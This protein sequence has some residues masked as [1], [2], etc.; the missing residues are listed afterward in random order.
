MKKPFRDTKV[1]K[2]LSSKGVDNV[3]NVASHVIP[4]V[5]AI[6]TIKDAILGSPLSPEDKMQALD[7][8]IQEKEIFALEIQDRENARNREIEIAR[9]GKKEWVQ[10]AVV[11]SVLL[12]FMGMLSFQLFGTV[13]PGNI[14]AVR[15]LQITLRDMMFMVVAYYVGSSMGSKRKTDLLKNE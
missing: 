14:D 13:P 15:E 10:P 2:F 4:G 6:D 5:K 12:M 9:T 7:L 1:G 3:L 8:L 11:V